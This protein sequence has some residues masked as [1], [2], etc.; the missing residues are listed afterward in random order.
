MTGRPV[1]GNRWD[2]LDGVWPDAQPRVS[3]VV[4]H[5]EQHDAL[6]RTLAALA[7]QTLAPAEVIVADDGSARPPA[8]PGGVRI[9]RQEDRGNRTASARNLGAAEATGD[10][11]C[12]LDADTAPEPDCLRRLTRL[13]ALAPEAVTVGRRRYAERDGTVLPEP[14]WLAEGWA[15]GGDLL[16]ADDRSYRYIISAVLATSRWFF[17]AVGPFDAS[18]NAYGGE[19]WDWAYRAWLAGAV[20]AHVPDAVAWHDGPDWSGRPGAADARQAVKNDETLRLARTVA[21]PGS[22]GHGVRTLRP[23]VAVTLAGAS[24]PGAAF[25]CV[26]SVLAALPEATVVV[27]DAVAGVFAGDPRVGTEP[28]PGA[29]I[30]V[31]LPGPVRVTG[32]GLC[33]AVAEAGAADRNEL[34]SGDGTVLAVLRSARAVAREGRWGR[35][36]GFERSRRPAAGL[37]PITGEPDLE[38]YLGGWPEG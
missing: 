23:D 3:V 21:V 17:E 20:L 24:S 13:P 6:A 11:L 4:V 30:L 14:A 26:D 5:Y 16:H 12:F 38:A 22:R 15:R 31:E 25:L 34:T 28:V 32:D 2:V 29:R 27:P 7:R 37:E 8:L 19:D 9:V 1:P 33:A 36:D 35:A 10:V 18:F